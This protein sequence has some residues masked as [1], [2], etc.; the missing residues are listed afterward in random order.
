MFVFAAL[1]CVVSGDESK[2]IKKSKI[3]K[4]SRHYHASSA[5]REWRLVAYQQQ[6]D[7][8]ERVGERMRASKRAMKSGK[9]K[10]ARKRLE[11]DEKL[12]SE[13]QE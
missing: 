1:T 12:L 5:S 11:K 8:N 2:K 7:V 9:T 3:S 13:R 10:N 4:I 6:H